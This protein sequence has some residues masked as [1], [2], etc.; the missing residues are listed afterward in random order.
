MRWSQLAGGV[1]LNDLLYFILAPGLEVLAARFTAYG[2][3]PNMA[4]R[5]FVIPFLLLGSPNLIITAV[6]ALEEIIN[7]EIGNV[8]V[9]VNVGEFFFV[10]SNCS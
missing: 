10:R 8:A 3:S 1:H 5:L 6:N 2:H 7:V 4:F 9:G